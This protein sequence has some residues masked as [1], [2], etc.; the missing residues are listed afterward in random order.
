MIVHCIV[1]TKSLTL[2]CYKQQENDDMIKMYRQKLVSEWLLFSVNS[3]IC[4]LFH[5]ENKVIINEIMM[6][7][8]LF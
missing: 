8:I 3:A 7:F 5:G 4:Q 6:R 1:L 2:H